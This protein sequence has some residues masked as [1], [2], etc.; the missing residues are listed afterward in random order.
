MSFHQL[1][2]T[3]S[4]VFP[5]SSVRKTN[6]KKRKE[7]FQKPGSV[8]FLGPWKNIMTRWLFKTYYSILVLHFHFCMIMVGGG[9]SPS[10]K[11]EW[12]AD[13]KK[14]KKLSTASWHH[15]LPLQQ[16]EICQ[17]KAAKQL[18]VCEIWQQKWDPHQLI[19]L[20]SNPQLSTGKHRTYVMI[21]YVPP[22]FPCVISLQQHGTKIVASN[23]QCR[24]TTFP[25]RS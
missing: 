4:R 10:W 22:L 20:F 17:K 25:V 1:L 18:R 2:E 11:N 8:L 21:R 7:S 13:L 16:L 5:K 12:M 14:W 24:D 15:P 23:Q 6:Q 9:D 19:Q 3:F